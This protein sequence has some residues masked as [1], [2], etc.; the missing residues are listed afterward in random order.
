M[1]L[2]LGYLCNTNNTTAEMY[3]I[4]IFASGDGSNAENIARHFAASTTAR[5]KCVLSNKSEAGVHRRMERLGIPSL[6]FAKQQWLEGTEI[7]DFLK[8]EEIDL[9]VL[10]GF[11]SLVQPPIIDAF[12]GRI[13]NI[14]PSLLPKFGGRGMWGMNVHRA[15]LEA[16]ERE[17][18]I[19]I[20]YV[21]N[22]MDCGDIILQ[23]HCPVA[24][25]DTP[26]TLCARVHALEYLHYPTVIASLLQ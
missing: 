15:V 11:L 18:G 14:H 22:E 20:H 23:A 9:I 21:N 1:S 6:T 4:A 16:G 10:A 19:T 8:S 25:D 13:I 12:P 26:E 3:N 2:L 24:P 5:V 17:S 7:A